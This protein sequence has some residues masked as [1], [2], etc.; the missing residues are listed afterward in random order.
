MA[1]NIQRVAYDEA[2]LIMQSIQSV[3]KRP[4]D[5]FVLAPFLIWYALKCRDMGKTPRALLL[6]AGIY[7]LFYNADEYKRLD[8][9]VQTGDMEKIA[10]VVLNQEI[11]F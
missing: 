1:A 2:G 4:F 10:T 9:A 8:K 7:Q 3:N 6:S 11:K 5:R